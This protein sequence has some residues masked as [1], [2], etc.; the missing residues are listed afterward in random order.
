MSKII[1]KPNT[2]LKEIDAKE[3]IKRSHLQSDIAQAALSL[4]LSLERQYAHIA[5]APKVN[6][7]F[8]G[9]FNHAHFN[10]FES[11]FAIVNGGVPTTLSAAKELADAWCADRNNYYKNRKAKA[12]DSD[13]FIGEKADNAFRWV[14][15][16]ILKQKHKEG[17]FADQAIAK[18]YAE[19]EKYRA[20][21]S[22]AYK[23]VYSIIDKA[24]KGGQEYLLLNDILLILQG[25]GAYHHAKRLNEITQDKIPLNNV[26]EVAR[27]IKTER[28]DK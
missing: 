17:R 20:D 15:H 3:I 22:K 8:S 16:C 27:L 7:I 21:D 6:D 18:K 14:V 11:Q 26:R 10:K 2:L 13:W 23:V 12:K 9:N 5:F 25:L 24:I 1:D 4:E 28:G 19:M